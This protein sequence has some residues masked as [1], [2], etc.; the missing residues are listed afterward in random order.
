M[1]EFGDGISIKFSNMGHFIG[2]ERWRHPEISIDTYEIIFVTAGEVYIEE[3]GSF[4]LLTEGDMLCLR[5]GLT[6]R[7]YKE[8][9]NTRFYWLHFWADNYNK[10]G[11]YQ[12]RTENTH[13]YKLFFRQ[14]NHLACDKSNNNLI[15]CKLAA[16]LLEALGEQSRKSKLFS[17]VSEHVRINIAAAPTVQSVAEAFGYNSDHLSRVFVKNS[18]IPLKAYI[19]RERNAYIKHLLLSTNMT[20][21]EIADVAS[22][23]NDNLLIKFFKYNNAMTP[24][25]FRNR[26]HASHTNNK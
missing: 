4:Y 14:M 20:V 26:Y 11:M 10:I 13:N 9:D 18:G 1:I 21:R 12:H 16:F 8:T 17:D 25:E 7:G 22:F 24:T 19:D 3:E 6:H 2:G 5:P 23:E 15:E